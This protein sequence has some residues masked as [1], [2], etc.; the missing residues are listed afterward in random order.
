MHF[1]PLGWRPKTKNYIASVHRII[2]RKTTLDHRKSAPTVKAEIEK[3]LGVIDHT[4][5]IRN[6]FVRLCGTQKAIPK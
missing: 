3:D 2:Q 4:N 1:E 6:Q 5:T